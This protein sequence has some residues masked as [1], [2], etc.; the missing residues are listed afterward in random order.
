MKRCV[1]ALCGVPNCGKT[2]LYNLITGQA[3]RTG[4]WPGVTVTY[5]LGEARAEFLPS[6]HTE[7]PLFVDL[8]GLYA[9]Q[10]CSAEEKLTHDYLKSKKANVILCVVNACAPA[11]G[12]SLALQL[13]TLG[14]PLLLVLNMTDALH[15]AGGRLNASILSDVLHIPV[16]SICA[17]TGDGVPRLIEKAL[18]HA[19]TG[20]TPIHPTLSAAERYKQIDFLLAR[21]FDPGTD[22]LTPVTQRIDRLALHRYIAWPLLAMVFAAVFLFV[23]AFPGP[24]AA[25]A[26]ANVIENAIQAIKNLLSRTPPLWHSLLTDGVFRGLAA[27]VSFLPTLLLLFFLTALLEDSGYL[28]RAAFLLDA[29]LRRLGLSG[30]SFFP[31]M[32]GFGCTVPAVLSTATLPDQRSR[33]LTALLIPY[34]S[35]SAKAPAYLYLSTHAGISA[36][37]TLYAYLLGF[38]MMIFV[39]LPLRSLTNAHQAPLIMELPAYHLPTLRG[40]MRVMRDKTRDFFV[41]AFTVIFITSLIV[42]FMQYFSPTLS[43][44]AQPEQSLLYHISAFLRP[45]FAPLGFDHPSCIAALLAGLL[46]KENILSVLS[47]AAPLSILFPTL[48]GTLSY[49][50]FVSLYPPCLASCA[51]IACECKSRRHMLLS[52]LLQTSVAWLAAFI[53]YR[54]FR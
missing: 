27:A 39:S 53:A 4:N 25:T 30:R 48:A 42:W 36:L 45:L 7:A 19:Q 18:G 8:P 43:R 9:M 23:F 46:A 26:L 5:S 17:R 1:I 13:M 54:V 38:A 14:I 29:P 50:T 52:V 37:G 44:A 12:L 15:A 34:L 2:T 3:Q 40:V 49:L 31:L 20:Q 11:Q 32:T 47:L 16:E 33:R 24:L 35:C 22:R 28:A 10:P 41:R 21:C 51:V 6:K